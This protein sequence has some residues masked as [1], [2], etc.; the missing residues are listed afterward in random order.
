MRKPRKRLR[1]SVFSVSSDGQLKRRRV[2]KHNSFLGH[3]RMA[4][5][6]MRAIRA[7]GTAS[8]LAKNI[9]C[10]IECELELLL[11]ALKTRVER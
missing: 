7:S 9:A 8:D 3:A 2:W 4:E 1:T 10:R 5:A 6:N 11:D